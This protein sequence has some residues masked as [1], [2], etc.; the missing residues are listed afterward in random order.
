MPCRIWGLLVPVTLSLTYCTHEKKS[1]RQ[2][3]QARDTARVTIQEKVDTYED[4]ERKEWQNPSLV[5]DRLEP[6]QGKTVADIGAGTGYFSFRMAD[7]G[8]HVLAIDIDPQLLEYIEERE[9]ENLSPES[10]GNVTTRLAS[11]DDP[12]LKPDEADVVL[13]VN[14]YTYLDDRVDYMKTVK[15][16][17]REKGRIFIVDYKTPDNPTGTPKEMIIPPEQVSDELKQAGFETV[18]I[19]SGSLPY[20]YIITASLK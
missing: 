13:L 19:D 12:G 5:I 17:L 4:P 8:A 16:G 10:R 3:E 14:T 2:W 6:L 15:K 11:P 18:D 9:S 1:T 20:Q 7:R